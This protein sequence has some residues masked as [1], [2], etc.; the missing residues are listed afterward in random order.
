M[1]A[2]TEKQQKVRVWENNWIRRIVEVKRADKRGMD[3]L[4][5]EVGVIESLIIN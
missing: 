3:E 1:T 4:R 5:V 2:L